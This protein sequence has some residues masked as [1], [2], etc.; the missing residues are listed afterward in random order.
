MNICIYKY[1]IVT[2][3]PEEMSGEEKR[4]GS[5]ELSLTWESLASC[6]GLLSEEQEEDWGVLV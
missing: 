2:Y 1:Y 4:A 5:E 3:V 6:G